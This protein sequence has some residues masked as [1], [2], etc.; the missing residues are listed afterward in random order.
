MKRP[1]KTLSQDSLG[2]WLSPPHWISPGAGL[3]LE[4]GQ[5]QRWLPH[6]AGNSF[7]SPASG[8]VMPKLLSSTVTV[9]S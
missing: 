7:W 5:G 3:G 2:N 8:T 4:W 9:L 1:R 6:A